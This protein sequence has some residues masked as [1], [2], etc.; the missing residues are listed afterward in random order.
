MVDRIGAEIHQV[1]YGKLFISKASCPGNVKYRI[2]ICE[3]LLRLLGTESKPFPVDIAPAV[4]PAIFKPEAFCDP[5][6]IRQS[7]I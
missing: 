3:Q 2:R 1:P 7:V 6:Q 4:R 5:C